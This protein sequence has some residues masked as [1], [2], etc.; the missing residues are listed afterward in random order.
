MRKFGWLCFLAVSIGLALAAGASDGRLALLSAL[1]PPAEAQQAAA[2][3]TAS[4]GG[5]ISADQ[6]RQTLDVLQNDAKRNQLIQVLQTIANAPAGNGA[7]ANAPAAGA[8][9]A[10][11][12]AAS[13]PANAPA[14]NTPSG[15]AAPASPAPAATPPAAALRSAREGVADLRGMILGKDGIDRQIDI[16]RLRVHHR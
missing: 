7:A 9:A 12:P 2:P 13:V 11:V 16:R 14:A 5:N 8:P 3:A 6:A 10:S 4:P 1:V 15:S